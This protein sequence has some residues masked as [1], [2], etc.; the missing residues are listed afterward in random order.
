MAKQNGT[1]FDQSFYG[2][3]ILDERNDIQV[4]KDIVD[5]IRNIASNRMNGVTGDW[6]KAGILANLSKFIGEKNSEE[7]GTEIEANIIDAMGY[8][9]FLLPKDL[10]VDVFPLNFSSVAI[11]FS[12]V[13]LGIKLS[14]IFDYSKGTIKE[15]YG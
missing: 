9:G 11:L 15:L 6:E 14:F 1:D 10:D 7:T 2:D 8:D 13:R 5:A 12:V 4:T 3:L